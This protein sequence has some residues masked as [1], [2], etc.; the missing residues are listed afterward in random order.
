[1]MRRY[2]VVVSVRSAAKGD[3]IISSY[4]EDIRKDISYEVVE[5]IA[6]DGAFDEVGR[7]FYCR[8]GI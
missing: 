7:S 6:Q 8:Q 2:K 3:S 5:D 1:M 4:P